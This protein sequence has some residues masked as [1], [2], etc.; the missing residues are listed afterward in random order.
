MFIT[1]RALCEGIKVANDWNTSIS[2][3]NDEVKNYLLWLMTTISDKLPGCDL[4]LRD[5]VATDMRRKHCAQFALVLIEDGKFG[6]ALHEIHDFIYGFGSDL[7]KSMT[8]LE[9]ITL[10]HIITTGLASLS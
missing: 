4:I 6:H 2:L 3:T 1:R 7:D 10:K 8:T 5:T 9:M